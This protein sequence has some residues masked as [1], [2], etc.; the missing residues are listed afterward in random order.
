MTTSPHYAEINCG[1]RERQVGLANIDE[2]HSF[3]AQTAH[4]LEQHC[5]TNYCKIPE[6]FPL[7]EEKES[8]KGKPFSFHHYFVAP[9]SI[10]VYYY[11]PRKK[12]NVLQFQG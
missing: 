4:N 11:T 6:K 7:I 9:G 3:L 1:S 10:G 8:F 2:Y 12:L 5:Q